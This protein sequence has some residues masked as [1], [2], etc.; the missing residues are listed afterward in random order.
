MGLKLYNTD[1]TAS[2]RIRFYSLYTPYTQLDA[3]TTTFATSGS[4]TDLDQ[5]EAINN[6]VKGLKTDSLW[7]EMKAVYPII[8]GT[9]TAHALNLVDPTKFKI[10]WSGGLTHSATG[11]SGSGVNGGGNTGVNPSVDLLQD[12]THLS[13]YCR[14]NIPGNYLDMGQSTGNRNDCYLY[15]NRMYASVNSA[16][17][18][19]ITDTNTAVTDTR[20]FYAVSRTTS[21]VMRGYQNKNVIINN[22][23]ASSTRP[24]QAITVMYMNG[25]AGYSPREYAFF[26]IGNGLTD[27]QMNKL[28]NRI[29]TFQTSLNRQV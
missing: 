6:L 12:S 28:Y 23:T 20:G 13:F 1:K 21:N 3:A 25:F 2:S 26:T 9:A 22:S 5:L 14:A 17:A 15:A 10:S 29:Q 19:S 16:T 11:V 4:I 27:D 24:N 18:N 8:G 7:T